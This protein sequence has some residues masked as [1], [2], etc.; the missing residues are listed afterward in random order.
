[1]RQDALKTAVRG[2]TENR[3]ALTYLA[4][5]ILV[6]FFAN[7]FFGSVNISARDILSALQGDT[8]DPTIRFIVLESRFPQA[9]TALLVGASLASAGLL[10]QTAFHNPLAG[11]SVLG[12]SPGASLGVA[13]VTLIGITSPLGCIGAALAGAIATTALLLFLST[14]LRNNLI[15]LITGL[16]LGYLI[17]AVITILG[18]ISTPEGLRSYVIWGMGD[19][20]SVGV[21]RLPLLALSLAI[22]MVLCILLIK[23]LNALQLGDRYAANLG[24]SIGA[25]RNV[26]L[27]IVGGITA[28][29][30]AFCG[31]VSFIGLAVPHIARMIVRTDDFRCLMPATMLSGSAVALLCNVLCIVPP[32]TVL[33]LNAVTPIV[34][35]P[36]IIYVVCRSRGKE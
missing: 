26:L 14:L 10:L 11:P 31:P 16:L 5:L 7:I 6:L 33:P 2:R 30:T 13:L 25:L 4:I 18:V 1:M 3:R 35:V 12:I 22:L 28:L 17:S 27:L 23:P 36:V 34:G 19:F 32:T 8:A 24:V 21:D 29:T 15:L 9:L 20:S